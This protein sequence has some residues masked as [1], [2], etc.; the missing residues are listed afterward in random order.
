MSRS[1]CTLN[2]NAAPEFTLSFCGVRVAQSV[3]FCEVFCRSLFWG[4]LCPFSFDH[5]IVCL[6]SASYYLFGI[7]KLFLK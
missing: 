1:D 5:C 4:F 2:V 6:T 3:V 7:F